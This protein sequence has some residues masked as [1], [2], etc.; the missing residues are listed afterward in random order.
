MDLGIIVVSYNTCELTLGCLE[1]VYRELSASA[2]NGHVWVIDN[3]SKDGS[4]AA[5]AERFPQ[6]KIIASLEN[7]GFARG[8]NLGA[9]DILSA[10][11]P[12]DY[13]LLLNPDTV[14][15]PGALAYLLAFMR[16]HPQTAVAGAQLLYADGSFQ[17]SAF[18]FPTLAMAFF[19]FWT[20]NHRLLDS[21]LNGRYPRRKYNTGQPF[22]IDHPLGAA[23]LVRVSAWQQVGPLDPAYFMYCEEIDWCLR[24]YKAGWRMYCVPAAKIIHYAGQSTRQFKSA[25]FVALWRSR[26]RLFELY[27]SGIYRTA[28]RTIVRIGLNRQIQH[29]QREAAAYL[30]NQTEAE[31]IIAAYRQVQELQD[32]Y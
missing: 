9:Q 4:A 12:P 19:D 24:A 8:V 6:A 11:N 30:L 7:L 25:M 21:P 31:S 10:D 14:I 23:M 28:V 2:I 18:H 15:Q 3:A 1:S 5:I 29:V 22:Q 20:I 26:Y 16:A 32:A 13:L 17:H 27:Y